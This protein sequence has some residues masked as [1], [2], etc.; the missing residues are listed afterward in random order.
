VFVAG[1]VLSAFETGPGIRVAGVSLVG[2]ALWLARFDIARYTVRRAGLPRFVALALLLGYVWLGI[3]GAL[4]ALHGAEV[5]GFPHDAELHAIF[6][7]FVFSMI[8]GQA[9]VV[10]PG[11][12]GIDIPFRRVFYVHLALLHAGLVL[13][14]GGDLTAPSRS[15]AGVGW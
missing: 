9:P 2:Y 3:G 1:L 8:F 10:F 14:I 5:A 12:L 11:V 13:R 15:P 4:W 6:V 7:G